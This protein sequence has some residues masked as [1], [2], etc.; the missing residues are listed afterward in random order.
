MLD[1]EVTTQPS[2]LDWRNILK[3]D[4]LKL[5]MRLLSDA[6][7]PEIEQAIKSAIDYLAILNR[8]LLPTTYNLYLPKIPKSGVIR[9]PF[10]PLRTV[11]S[12]AYLD[13]NSA[14]QT[15]S[16]SLYVLRNDKIGPAEIA[17]IDKTSLPFLMT[18]PRA[19]TVG[20]TAGYGIGTGQPPI[21]DIL[22]RAVKILAAHY[23]ENPEATI[24][25]T[26]HTAYSRK[27]EF[28]LDEMISRLKVP[29][30][31]GDWS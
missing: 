16:S 28:G 21:P 1:F 13:Q 18:H 24:N 23:M 2:A 12:M 17:F 4:E 31:Y 26:R 29:H 14:S 6:L 22:K 19:L 30:E 3:R 9:L 27:V 5:H 11:N 15:L 20:F 25:D 7:D 10:P 8:S